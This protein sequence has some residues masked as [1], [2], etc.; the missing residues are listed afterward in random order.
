MRLLRAVLSRLFIRE[1]INGGGVCPT[2]LYRWELV[3]RENWQVYLHNFVGDDWS[4]DMH[5]H[6]KRFISIGLRGGYVEETPGQ[7]ERRY[8]APWVRSFPAEH[9]HRLRLVDGR[10]CWTLVVVL[11]WVRGW[12]FW[13]EGSFVPWREYVNSDD[14]HDRRSCP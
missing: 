13:R 12:G 14:A 4:L 6:P 1:E 3:R 8:R 10:P 2:Y 7:V 5:D 11:K 9:I